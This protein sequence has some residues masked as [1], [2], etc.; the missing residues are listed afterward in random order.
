MIDC[1]VRYY[2]RGV[3]RRII[4]FE[5]VAKFPAVPFP[6]SQITDGLTVERVVFVEE[7]APILIIELDDF[8]ISGSISIDGSEELVPEIDCII[9]EMQEQGWVVASDT[10]HRP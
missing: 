2:I 4:R 5:R 9:E 10:G 1:L 8:E 7:S 3:Q 6:G